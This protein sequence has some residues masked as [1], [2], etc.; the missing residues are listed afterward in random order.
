MK[1]FRKTKEGLFICEECG[2]E[3]VRICGLSKHINTKHNGTREYY[4][5]WLKNKDDG[6]CKICNNEAEFVS[7]NGYK[8]CCKKH[9]HLYA[10]QIRKEKMLINLKKLEKK[11][12][13]HV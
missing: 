7:L 11:V 3:F 5:K 4:D 2:R 9:I 6:K 1:E 8:D 12:N 13:K 10:G